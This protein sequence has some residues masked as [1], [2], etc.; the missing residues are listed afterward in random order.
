M[1]QRVSAVRLFIE[2]VCP[3]GAVAHPA[4]I[5]SIYK[6]WKVWVSA[7][8]KQ[9]ISKPWVGLLEF[10]AFHV[11]FL[12]FALRLVSRLLERFIKQERGRVK[13]LSLSILCHEL[14]VNYEC[15]RIPMRCTF[16]LLVQYM[17]CSYHSRQY[18]LY[19]IVLYCI[20]LYC[21]AL[22]CIVLY[23]IM[24]CIVLYYRIIVLFCIV[25]YCIVLYCIIVLRHWGMRLTSLNPGP[26]EWLWDSWK[27]AVK[28]SVN[29][30]IGQWYSLWT[31]S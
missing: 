3:P 11:S 25:L 9:S 16:Y 4:D 30:T 10:L 20:V 27:T 1:W 23:C 22:Y 31:V 28:L 29:D 14:R 19:C 26:C 17:E 7:L 6:L 24:Y 8:C 21:V 5:K 13:N 15:W 2:H 12:T 18:V